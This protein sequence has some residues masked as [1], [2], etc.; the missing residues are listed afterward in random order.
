MQS[1]ETHSADSARPL[2][3]PGYSERPEAPS[4]LSLL[5][6]LSRI[7]GLLWQTDRELRFVYLA[8]AGPLATSI[9]TQDYIGQ[10]ISRL[11]AHP[12]PDSKV[13]ES[14]HAAL[15]GECSS[16]MCEL[17]DR[18][19][20]AHLQP[21]I[22]ESSEIAGVIGWAM[23]VTGNTTLGLYTCVGVLLAMFVIMNL[24]FF[25]YKAQQKALVAPR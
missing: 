18:D 11:C 13:E 15:R 16:F 17:A 19:L 22:G 10:P 12:A 14:H 4:A 20:E 5:A 23:D 25:R 21:L 2:P 7:P 1:A 24:F 3:E 8:A 9:K 6:L